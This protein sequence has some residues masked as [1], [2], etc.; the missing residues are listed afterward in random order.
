[1]QSPK[2]SK[3]ARKREHLAL[4]ALGE[5]LIEL[6][7]RQL[8]DLALE[9][10]LL[11]AVREARGMRAHGALRRQKQLIGKLMRE[12]DPEPIRAALDALDRHDNAGKEIFHA[13]ERWRDRVAAEGAPALEEFYALTGGDNS[14]LSELARQHQASASDKARRVLRRRMF[15]EIHK[16][17]ALKMQNAPR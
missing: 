16:E 17:L 8:A 10:D 6:T 11:H 12:A 1:M 9:E 7:D 2:P 3:S 4:Q 14:A 15:G 13:A 5:R